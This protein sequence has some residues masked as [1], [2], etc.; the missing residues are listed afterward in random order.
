MVT[1]SLIGAR[2][3][4][5]RVLH[6]GSCILAF[7]VSKYVTFKYSYTEIDI[8]PTKKTKVPP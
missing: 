6:K 8:L 7:A 5:E 2:G 4:F 1:F 3:V